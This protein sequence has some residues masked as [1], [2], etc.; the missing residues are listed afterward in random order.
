MTSL[1]R[2]SERHFQ[3]AIVELATLCQWRC[4]HVHD[5]RRSAPGWPDL[6]LLRGT[7]FVAAELKTAKGRVRPE[8]RGWLD[9]LEVA[10]VEVHVWRPSHWPEI[11]ATL[12]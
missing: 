6:V 8:Q 7:R 2:V 5:A 10:G 1:P 4:F 3:L 11:K 9:A 12:R